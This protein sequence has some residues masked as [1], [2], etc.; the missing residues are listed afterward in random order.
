MIQSGTTTYADMYYFEEEIARVT[1]EAGLRGVLG[2]TIIQFPVADAKTPAEGL[3]RAEAFIKEFARRRSDRAGGRAALDVHARRG[4]A[5]GDPRA[6]RS[7]RARRCSSIWRRRRT[8]STTARTRHKATPAAVPG[9]HRLLGPADARRARRLAVARGHAHPRAPARRRGAQSGKQ[10]EA[11]ERRGQ[12]GRDAPRRHRGRASAPTARRATTTSTCSRRCARRRF[13]PSCRPMDPRALPGAHGARDGDHRRRPRP[14]HGRGDRIAR[15]RQAR[16][17]DRRVDGGGAADADVRSVLPPRL[18]HARRRR[19]DDDRERP[20]A[21]ARPEG[22]DAERSGRAPRGA[23]DGGA[24][25]GRRS[26]NERTVWTR[27]TIQA[28]RARARA[29][30]SSATTRRA[31]TSISSAC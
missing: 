7:R 18:R 19:E 23:R 20:G 13:W 6:G 17:P 25:S 15:A 11:R 16:R 27:T 14:R 22:A 1:K 29:A 28:R 5:Q 3:V 8:K 30:R 21:D 12:G 10:H 26:R 2:Q 24:G 9:I 4:H 31:R